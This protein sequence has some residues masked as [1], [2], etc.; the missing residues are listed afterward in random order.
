MAAIERRIRSPV[1]GYCEES[2]FNIYLALSLCTCG[3]ILAFMLTDPSSFSF[4]VRSHN[5]GHVA[6][7]STR[8]NSN[9]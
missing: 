3:A 1:G 8:E 2:V 7:V 9:F 5:K 6:P 4:T